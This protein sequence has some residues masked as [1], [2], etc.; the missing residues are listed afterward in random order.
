MFTLKYE[1]SSF[2][3][4]LCDFVS[5]VEHQVQQNIHTAHFDKMKVNGDTLHIT[6]M[7]Q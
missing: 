6:Y 5:S 4:N 1:F 3:P 2:F 7:L